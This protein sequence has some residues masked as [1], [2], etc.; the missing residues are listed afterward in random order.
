ME[1]PGK[2]IM[3]VNRRFTLIEMLVVI[4]IIVLLAGLIM[5]ALS[6]AKE[7]ARRAECTSNLTQMSKGLELYRVNNRGAFP[8]WITMLQDNY[9][10]NVG[11]KSVMTCPGDETKGKDGGRPGPEEPLYVAGSEIDQ[12]ENAD[13]DGPV[14]GQSFEPSDPDDDDPKNSDDV[15]GINCSYI[16]EFNGY[17]C[18]WYPAYDSS[19]DRNSDS[20]ISWY[21]AKMNQ[22]DDPAN[23]W[24]GGVVPVVRCFWHCKGPELDGGDYVL[25]VQHNYAVDWSGPKWEDKY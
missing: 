23:P 6:R 11:D 5:P 8:P 9:L 19:V 7:N 18:E 25:N 15:G 17:E 4:G 22:I 20:I 24:P 2:D 13:K 10:P 14:V 21:E 12:F 3:S 1:L 16:F